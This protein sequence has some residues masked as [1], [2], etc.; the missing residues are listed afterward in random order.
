MF[1]CRLFAFVA[2]FALFDIYIETN[3]MYILLYRSNE[4]NRANRSNVGKCV[5]VCVLSPKFLT[6]GSVSV[7]E[8]HVVG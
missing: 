2:V 7:P 4:S 6:G 1:V 5:V 8:F 3:H